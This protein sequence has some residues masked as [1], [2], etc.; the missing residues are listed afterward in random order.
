MFNQDRLLHF[1]NVEIF[2]RGNKP[3]V[4]GGGQIAIC[5]A[6]VTFHVTLFK[7]RR[8]LAVSAEEGFI[9]AQQPD[10]E[11]LQK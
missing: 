1:E 11:I 4:K 3:W 2:R 7:L 10:G 8:R 6:H 9:E 5:K